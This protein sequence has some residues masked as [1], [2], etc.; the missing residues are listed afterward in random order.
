VMHD[1]VHQIWEGPDIGIYR[2]GGRLSSFC[3]RW[4]LGLNQPFT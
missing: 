1:T 3:L 4:R 2:A